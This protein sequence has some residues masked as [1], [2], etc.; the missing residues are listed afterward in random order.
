MTVE[1]VCK[2]RETVKKR[3]PLIIILGRQI[4]IFLYFIGVSRIMLLNN[5]F[6]LLKFDG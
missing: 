3:C 1:S 4:I 6:S 5:Y 2:D